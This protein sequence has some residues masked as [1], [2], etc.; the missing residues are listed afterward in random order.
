MSWLLKFKF[1]NIFQ[2][3]EYYNYKF[4]IKEIKYVIKR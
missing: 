3:S 4:D 2:Y 1:I